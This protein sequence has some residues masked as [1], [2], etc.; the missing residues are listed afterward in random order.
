MQQQGPD[1]KKKKRAKENVRDNQTDVSMF[2]K[3]ASPKLNLFNEKYSKN[4]NIVN[5]YNNVFLIKFHLKMQLI[6]LMASYIII[7]LKSF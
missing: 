5:Y 6:N 4:S 3:E 2:L 7:N 1:K